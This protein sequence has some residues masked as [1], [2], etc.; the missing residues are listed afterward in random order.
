MKPSELLDETYARMRGTGP[1]FEGWL[2]NHG[3]MAADALI[4]LGRADEVQRWVAGY[5]RK[6]EDAPGRRW[7]IDEKDWRDP[8]GDPS[9][10]G[11][12]CEFFGWLVRDRPWTEVLALWW[13]RLLPG[14]VAS[15]SHGLIRTG[16]VVRALAEGVTPQRLDELGQALGYWAARWQPLP[17]A[18]RP[19]GTADAA[20]ALAATAPLGA[21]GGF[22]TRLGQLE[23]APDWS[24][25]VARLRAPGRP[26]DVPA[27][28]DT[29]VDAAVTGYGQWAH[30]SP[31][32][33]VHA[34]TAPR[35]AALVLPSLPEHLWVPT[36]ERAWA[37]CAAITSIYRPSAP[38]PPA[39]ATERVAPTADDVTDLAVAS[40]DEHAIK[41]VEVAQESHRRGNSAALTS[42]ARAVVLITSDD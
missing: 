40:R 9:R 24:A 29:L 17:P 5:L 28:L 23:D 1:E 33:M 37:V 7:L 15:A 12:W 10:L 8:L 39:S 26:A 34:A 31:I 14:A 41:F 42:G 6:L 32:M 27:A 2:A 30:G 4:R 36:F 13:P 19:V 25:A 38:P 22:R 18:A 11:D 20:A 35:A 3:P 21:S 16:H